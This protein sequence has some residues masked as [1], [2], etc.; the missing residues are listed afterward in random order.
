[1]FGQKYRLGVVLSVHELISMQ[2]YIRT[3]T[4]EVEGKEQ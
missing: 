2:I 4:S 1:M 3:F